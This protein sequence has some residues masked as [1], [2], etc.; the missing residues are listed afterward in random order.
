MGQIFNFF[1]HLGF[2]PLDKRKKFASD[3]NLIK[4]EFQDKNK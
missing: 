3:L 4:E 2:L 1:N